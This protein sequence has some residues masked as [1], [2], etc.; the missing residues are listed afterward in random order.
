M[1]PPRE[2]LNRAYRKLAMLLHPD[3]TEVDGAQESF[4]IIGQA[5]NYILKTFRD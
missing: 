1:S 2:E 3:K 4:K 5:R